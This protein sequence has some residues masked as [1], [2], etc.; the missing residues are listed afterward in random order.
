[1]ST[2]DQGRTREV[3]RLILFES[4]LHAWVFDFI[5]DII[6]QMPTSIFYFFLSLFVT[7]QLAY[8][9]PDRESF[10]QVDRPIE[11]VPVDAFK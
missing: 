4:S 3:S 11:G 2:S 5:S 10:A 1:M 9:V 8:S 7:S 6:P